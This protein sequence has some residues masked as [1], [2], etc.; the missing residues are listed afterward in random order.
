[1]LISVY[2]KIIGTFVRFIQIE[3]VK[4]SRDH[5]QKLLFISRSVFEWLERSRSYTLLLND[6]NLRIVSKKLKAKYIFCISLIVNISKQSTYNINKN[7]HAGKFVSTVYEMTEKYE[8]LIL[9]KASFEE[10]VSSRNIEFEHLN[11][12]KI[13]KCKPC[14]H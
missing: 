6:E 13:N 7:Y 11:K 8:D 3:E 5:V 2:H 9:K 14:L 4:S 1:M 12:S 10:N